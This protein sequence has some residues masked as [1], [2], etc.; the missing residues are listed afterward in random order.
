MYGCGTSSESHAGE[1]PILTLDVERAKTLLEEAGYDGS[2]IILMDPADNSTLH[3][4][5][6][7]A[8]QSLRRIGLTVEVQAMDWST[9]TQR[10]AS[11]DSVGEGGW[12]VFVTNST[13]AGISN[14]LIHSFAKNCDKAWYGWPCEEKVPNLIRNWALE[15]NSDTRADL[16]D[17][18]Q[19]LNYQ[20]VTYIPLGQYRP[21]VAYRKEIQDVIPSPSLF[22]WGL[23]KSTN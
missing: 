21:V 22:Y 16:V 7:V 6:L 23:K 10:R 15:S 14:P 8:A 9:L 20:N 2:P 5:A 18:I 3:P 17:Q 1:E 13:I 11:K 19:E 12:N 4:A